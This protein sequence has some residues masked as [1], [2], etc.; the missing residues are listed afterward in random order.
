MS[1][2]N[3]RVGGQT[4][5]PYWLLFPFGL[6][7]LATLGLFL[8]SRYLRPHTAGQAWNRL[9]RLS[10]LAGEEG[11]PGETPSELGRRLAAAYP[12]AAH[13]IRELTDSF[14]VAAYAPAETA[15]RRSGDVVERWVQIR[16]HLVRRLVQRLRPAW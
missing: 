14:V 9:G 13:P 10:R 7:L 1:G 16:P 15:R 2:R 12:E 4:Q 11:P 5:R 8:V 6:L 3:G